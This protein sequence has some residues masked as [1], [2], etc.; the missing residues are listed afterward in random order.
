MLEISFKLI[1]G[2]PGEDLADFFYLNRTACTRDLSE[3]KGRSE[4]EELG[5]GSF[6]LCFL[7]KW[8]EGGVYS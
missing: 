3:K 2:S 4:A 7:A 8:L 1:L 6:A 5:E